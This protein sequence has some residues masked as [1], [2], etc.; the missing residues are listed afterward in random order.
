MI[1]GRSVPEMPPEEQRLAWCAWFEAHNIDPDD[2]AV[3]GRIYRDEWTNRISYDG[4]DR[5]AGGVWEGQPMGPI[6]VRRFIQLPA[7]PLPFPE[8][9]E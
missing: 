9:V 6:R 8:F 4:Y 2:V 5:E 1:E 7:T 3:P